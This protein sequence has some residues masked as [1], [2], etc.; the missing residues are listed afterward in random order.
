MP[1][2]RPRL[3]GLLLRL[4]FLFMQLAEARLPEPPYRHINAIA[5]HAANTGDVKKEALLNRALGRCR[6]ADGGGCRSWRRIFPKPPRL[7]F[8]RQ[9]HRPGKPVSSS[10]LTRLR[11][12]L[13]LL[14]EPAV[15][16]DKR[17]TGKRV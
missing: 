14:H 10:G 7:L 8:S 3:M 2:P 4:R 13:L 12:K 17:L 5:A 16:H 11:L 6:G 1:I 9:A 15:A